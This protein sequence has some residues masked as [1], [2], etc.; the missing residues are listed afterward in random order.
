MNKRDTV[1]SGFSG[2]HVK[3]NRRGLCAL[4]V[5]SFAVAMPGCERDEIHAYRI[6]KETATASA[7]GDTGQGVAPAS[8]ARVVWTLPEGWVEAPNDEPMRLAT[9]RAG[10]GGNEISLSAFPGDAGG[11][12]ANVNRWRGQLGM[13]AVDEAS[14]IETMESTASNGATVAIVDLRSPDGA[15]MLGAIVNP[16][17][18]MT[19]FVKAIG[20]SEPLDEIVESFATFAHS[21]HLDTAPA[22]AHAGHNRGAETVTAQ[23]S[24]DQRLAN[25]T[26]PT[27]WAP[28][29]GA[30]PILS[31]SFLA[32]NN[33]G[34]ARITVTRLSGA[35][36]GALAN[37]NR[38]RGQLGLS[39]VEQLGP[40]AGV[41]SDS[42]L[43]V[44]LESPDATRRMMAAI[45][46]A[47][48]SMY[49]FK[50]TGPHAGA[51]AEIERFNQL[52]ARVGLGKA[53]Q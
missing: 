42:P 43:M 12:L 44:D 25:W 6:P 26:P 3:L 53:D 41:V 10:N 18:G 24:V 37:I 31:A 30:S 40:A 23:E 8:G 38:W 35:G 47:D 33:D 39:P 48:G 2:L 7:A 1:S 22:D 52:V 36:G 46:E 4:C 50:M 28:E 13:E 19:W 20:Q 16:G 34:G 11:V 21:I 5:A 51:G 27:N 29:Q 32:N 15:R 9:F 49:Y 45:V 17:D 14:L